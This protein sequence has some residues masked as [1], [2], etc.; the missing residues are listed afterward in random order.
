MDAMGQTL[1]AT[2]MENQIREGDA[3]TFGNTSSK[4]LT[5]ARSVPLKGLNTEHAGYSAQAM[6]S[7]DSYSW[8]T[9]CRDSSFVSGALLFL[10]HFF[11]F[12]LFFGK[13]FQ[14]ESTLSWRY[15]TISTQ[16]SLTDWQ[17]IRVS[18]FRRDPQSTLSAALH[19]E[20][21]NVFQGFGTCLK[22]LTGLKGGRR[23]RIVKANILLQW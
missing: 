20:S 13:H 2:S 3:N 11:S 22:R 21:R 5:G 1:A 8:W 14:P 9:S 15:K 16:M 6:I 10:T 23:R 12:Y 4:V 18:W 17:P 19:G 7:W